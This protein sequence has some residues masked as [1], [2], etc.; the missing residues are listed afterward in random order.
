MTTL[1]HWHIYERCPHMCPV[2]QQFPSFM[3]VQ[4]KEGHV[5]TKSMCRNTQSCITCPSP[6]LE[7]IQASMHIPWAKKLEYSHHRAP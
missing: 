6:T 2:K 1:K 3:Y 4:Q 5:S 7:T